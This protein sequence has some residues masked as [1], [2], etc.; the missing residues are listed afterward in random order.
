MALCKPRRVLLDDHGDTNGST[1]GC[2]SD[3]GDADPDSDSKPA[4]GDK[5]RNEA[6][7]H[8]AEAAIYI[9]NCTL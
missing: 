7:W 3:S 2:E 8:V 6:G 5:N 1:A 9:F 4:S